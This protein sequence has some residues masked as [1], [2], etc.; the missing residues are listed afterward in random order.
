MDNNAARHV[1]A[2]AGLLVFSEDHL[3]S[4]YDKDEEETTEPELGVE[5]AKRRARP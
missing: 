3:G 1:V 5:A 4:V 2:T